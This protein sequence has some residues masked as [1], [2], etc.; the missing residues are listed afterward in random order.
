M[1]L[2][3]AIDAE[4][5]LHSIASVPGGGRSNPPLAPWDSRQPPAVFHVRA[6]V[7][8]DPLGV[9]EKR[10][11]INRT[12][13]T[14]APVSSIGNAAEHTSVSEHLKIPLSA[15]TAFLATTRVLELGWAIAGDQRKLSLVMDSEQDARQAGECIATFCAQAMPAVNGASADD[16]TADSG[17]QHSGGGAADIIWRPRQPPQPSGDDPPSPPAELAESVLAVPASAEETCQFTVDVR[18]GSSSRSRWQRHTVRLGE[19]FITLRRTVPGT[20]LGRPPKVREKSLSMASLVA[21]DMNTDDQNQFVVLEFLP[22]LRERLV[23]SLRFPTTEE[24]QSCFDRVRETRRACVTQPDVAPSCVAKLQSVQQ[25]R[26]GAVMPRPSSSKLHSAALDLP[27]AF[28]WDEFRQPDPIRVDRVFAFLS[29]GFTCFVK[30]VVDV[31][32]LGVTVIPQENS[33]G[34]TVEQVNL[35]QS[36][37]F[38]FSSILEVQRD[39]S[40]DVAAEE[41]RMASNWNHRPIVSGRRGRVINPFVRA[42]SIPFS[43]AVTL[44]PPQSHLVAIRFAACLAPGPTV[45][46]RGNVGPPPTLCLTLAFASPV[47]AI[48]VVHAINAGRQYF[49]MSLVSAALRI[50]LATAALP[51]EKVDETED[52]VARIVSGSGF[53]RAA[54]PLTLPPAHLLPRMV[55]SDEGEVFWFI[56]RKRRPKPQKPAT[57]GPAEAKSDAAP[58]EEAAGLT[59]EC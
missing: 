20:C 3:D 8:E 56:P 47:D 24:A 11:T 14:V 37:H 57:V 35:D 21:V 45:V 29:R 53:Q 31:D 23:L 30:A 32:K 13:V 54:R 6:W 5:L 59:L 22:E 49:T 55:T 58:V 17:S 39:A 19:H 26:V 52:P 41:A 51:T 38:P 12:G 28:Q 40:F 25:P 48:D 10:V 34:Y 36:I 1:P 42:A 46:S 44:D 15:L 18:V 33:L 27:V 50:K 9:R 43:D 16:T 7:E 4:E 2:V